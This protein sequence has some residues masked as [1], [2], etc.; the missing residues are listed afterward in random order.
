MD[1]R[2]FFTTVNAETRPTK[3][4]QKAEL[5]VLGTG[6]LEIHLPSESLDV[7]S[8]LVHPPDKISDVAPLAVHPSVAP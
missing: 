1:G 8:L 5:G 7:R 2:S 6:R 4:K 3:L